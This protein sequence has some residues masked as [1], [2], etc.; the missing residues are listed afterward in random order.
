LGP[1]TEGKQL[2]IAVAVEMILP[3][4]SATTLRGLY[5]SGA[6]INVV[7]QR[8]VD[9]FG[10]DHSLFYSKPVATFID[11]NHL[12]L[13]KPYDLSLRCRDSAGTEKIVGPQRFWAA[14]FTGYDLI[15]ILHR[16]LSVVA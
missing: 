15:Q 3:D 7:S 1:Q 9:R 8:M 2:R 6:E 10:L 16:R 13:N 5:D 14:N 4:G 11:S 12:Q